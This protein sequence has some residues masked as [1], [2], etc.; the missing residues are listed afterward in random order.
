M[1]YLLRTDLN[2]NG[3][4]VFVKYKEGNIYKYFLKDMYGN[5][6]VVDK[7]EIIRNKDNILNV[8]VSGNTIRLVRSKE[9]FYIVDVVSDKKNNRITTRSIKD[10]NGK[11]YDFKKDKPALC[12]FIDIDDMKQSLSWC[13]NCYS[14]RTKIKWMPTNKQG[15]CYGQV[16]LYI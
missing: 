7:E 4:E 15:L 12:S 11:E 5:T 16:F 2:D 14:E 10:I 1:K 9:P 8:S 13:F 6:T 3:N